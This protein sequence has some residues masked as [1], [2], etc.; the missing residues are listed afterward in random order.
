MST[1]SEIP[2]SPSLNLRRTALAHN[3]DHGQHSLDGHPEHA[4]RLESVLSL[5]QK[6]GLQSQCL[7][8]PV[9]AA[10]LQQVE[11]VHRPE[12]WQRLQTEIQSDQTV[13]LDTDTY[14][15]KDSLQ[16]ALLAAGAAL[17]V[18]EEVWFGRADNGM[19]LVRPPGHHATS[20]Q[21][22]GF[23]LLNNAAIAARWAQQQLGARRVAI[24]DFD[25][26]HGNGTQEIFYA[27]PKVLY[28]SLHQYPLFPMTGTLS[29]TGEG[30]GLGTNCNLPLPAGAGDECL[31]QLLDKIVA[32]LVRDFR[33]ELVL[34]SAGFDGH[35]RDPLA[36]LNLSLEG[37]AVLTRNLLTLA[38][39]TSQG[40]LVVILEGGYEPQVLQ[41]GVFNTLQLLMGQQELLDPF[42]PSKQ[43]S[44]DIS[45]LLMMVAEQ[46]NYVR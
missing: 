12:L 25:V 39:E 41:C 29:E 30:P 20:G 2:D 34:V 36:Q 11:M 35:W 37:Y 7:L 4:Y 21:S 33:P 24:L 38:E 28:V 43:E 6:T 17:Q 45:E 46:W 40:K 42:G 8:L 16:T 3:R 22:M 15:Q 31:S 13:W 14:L 19:A 9:Q 32:P 44:V 10:T 23:C 27:D 5:L 1:N 18:T 26:H